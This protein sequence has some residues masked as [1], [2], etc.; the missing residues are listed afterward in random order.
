MC[1][2]CEGH[3]AAR[4]QRTMGDMTALTDRDSR[5]RS[6]HIPGRPWSAD[7]RNVTESSC[8]RELHHHHQFI[9]Q[10]SKHTEVMT[11]Q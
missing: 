1:T 7:G 3:D 5:R 10:K 11:G 2:T 9:C 6:G 4:Q 8:A